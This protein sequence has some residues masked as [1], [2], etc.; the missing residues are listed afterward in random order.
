MIRVALLGL[1][2]NGSAAARRLARVLLSDPLSDEQAWERSLL[3][4]TNDGISL[5]LKYGEDTELLQSSPLLNTMTIPS[6]YL[7]KHNVEVLITPLGTEGDTTDADSLSTLRDSVLVPSLTM[8]NATSGR[9]GFVR[10]PVHRA[11]LV[12]EGIAGAVQYGRLPP[13]LADGDLITAALSVPLRPSSGSQSA[14]EEA[15]T[16]SVD[17]DLADHA[18]ALFRQNKANGARFSEEWQTS[19]VSILGNWM[20]GARES[21][22]GELHPVLQSVLGSILVNASRAVLT[23]EEAAVAYAAKHSVPESKRD[24]LRKAVAH[25]ADVSHHDLQVNLDSAFADSP[26][27]KRTSWWRLF[28]RIDDVTVSASDI[29]RRS[30]LH[31]SE[32]GL[33]Y[34]AGSIAEAGLASK[35]EL[36]SFP[37]SSEKVEQPEV[38]G[39]ETAPEASAS[40]E[41]SHMP[42][43]V[44]QLQERTELDAI[45]V[46]PWP[47]NIALSRNHMLNTLV[48]ELHRKAQSSL[49][50]SMSTIGGS[51]ALSGWFYLATGGI[52]L[53]ESGAIFALGLVWSLRRLQKK[54]GHERQVFSTTVREDARRV[55]ADVENRL[56]TLVSDGGRTSVPASDSEDWQKA[57]NAIRSAQSELDQLSAKT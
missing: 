25:W 51:A 56:R 41:L 4:S 47:Q 37:A 11:V 5:L 53:Y 55:I 38:R 44:T 29:L 23:A 7:R 22:G 20:A 6:G 28:W 18:L 16:S 30:W 1:G 21:V 10:Y 19:R 14:E 42:S 50:G 15:L 27:W 12:A 57:R 52:G 2:P 43:M 49:L 45:F 8:P 48:P 39:D 26:S 40:V 17:I 54:W 32:Q 3:E 36:G 31:E 13:G 46:R 24:E 33:A 35:R 34:L 9:V